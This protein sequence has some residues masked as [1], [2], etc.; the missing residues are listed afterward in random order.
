MVKVS[1]VVPV[2]ALKVLVGSKNLSS[3][4]GYMNPRLVIPVE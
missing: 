4:P 3:C 2:L 1:Y